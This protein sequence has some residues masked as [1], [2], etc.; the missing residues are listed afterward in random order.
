MY[1]CEYPDEKDKVTVEYGADLPSSLYGSAFPTRK[2]Y[3]WLDADFDYQSNLFNLNNIH[4]SPNSLLRVVEA[5]SDKIS[6]ITQPWMYLGML[7][8][9]FCWHVE[10]LFIHSISHNHLGSTKTWYVIPGK[11]KEDFDRYV[12]ERCESKR[13]KNLLEKITLMVDPLEL[14]KHGIPVYKVNQRER[15]F[16]ATFLKVYFPLL[17]LITADFHTASTL[18][19]LSILFTTMT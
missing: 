11:H 2:I 4:K 17:R 6:G 15:D 1:N 9:T 16:V 7:F 18:A 10:D 13:K 19:K 8:A 5:K 14:I 12:K 3:N